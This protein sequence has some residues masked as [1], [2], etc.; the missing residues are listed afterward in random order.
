MRRFSAQ[1]QRLCA[2]THR[3]CK[4]GTILISGI[5]IVRDLPLRGASFRKKMFAAKLPA[6]RAERPARFATG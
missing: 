1:S 2:G 3:L 4:H 6:F 5:L